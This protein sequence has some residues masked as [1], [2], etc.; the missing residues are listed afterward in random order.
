MQ[1]ALVKSADELSALD[2]AR[3]LNV[4]LNRLYNLLRLGRLAA[5]KDER[6]E[7]RVSVSSVEDR[8]KMRER[9]HARAVAG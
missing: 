6:G 2:A 3:R 8:L 4:D 1:T 5:R 9:Q 7:W